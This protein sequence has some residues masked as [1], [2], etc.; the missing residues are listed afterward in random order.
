MKIYYQKNDDFKEAFSK[1]GKI[2]DNV[3]LSELVKELSELTLSDNVTYEPSIEKFESLACAKAVSDVLYG[4]LPVEIGYC[5]GHNSM[6]NAVEYHRSSEIDVC[7]TE[8]VLLLGL[9]QDIDSN[10]NYDTSK[11]VA[12]VIDAGTSVELYAT[13]LH[14]APCG[15]NG[16]GFAVGVVLPKGTNYPLS[17]KHAETS[18]GNDEDKLITAKNKWL[19]C[20]PSAE[21]EKGHFPG[22][23]G[24][25]INIDDIF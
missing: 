17:T 4:E 19:I 16:K 9:Q 14:Y 8:A 24:E 18:V 1:Y 7:A 21:S 12:F 13:T 3:D 25:N 23:Y 5:A 20:H 6:L 15:I 10:F 2:V 22:L 11:M